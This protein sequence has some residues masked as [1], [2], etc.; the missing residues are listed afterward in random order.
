[1]KML[2]QHRGD[3]SDLPVVRAGHEARQS[4]RGRGGKN[5]QRGKRHHAGEREDFNF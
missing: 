5:R 2:H 4:I 1:M 3:E